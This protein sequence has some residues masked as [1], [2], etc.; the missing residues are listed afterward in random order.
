[1]LGSSGTKITF[2]HRSRKWLATDPS[3]ALPTAMMRAVPPMASAMARCA[4]AS[5]SSTS[6]ST[7]A[8]AGAGVA[9]RADSRAERRAALAESRADSSATSLRPARSERM[10]SRP[11]LESA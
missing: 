11:S 5:S 9:E 6:S 10:R 2:N 7:A 1:M 3:A 4:E 8:G